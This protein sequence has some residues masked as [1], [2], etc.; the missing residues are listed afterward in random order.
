MSLDISTCRRQWCRSTF[1]DNDMSRPP[2][3]LTTLIFRLG[4]IH[5][6]GQFRKKKLWNI[7]R[8]QII[9]HYR[10]IGQ[11]HIFFWKRKQKSRK[12][13][14]YFTF[15]NNF[16]LRSGTP[17]FILKSS[18]NLILHIL[19]NKSTILTFLEN[20]FFCEKNSNLKNAKNIFFLTQV[21]LY[22]KM[23]RIK[24]SETFRMNV[25]Y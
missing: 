9:G 14:S 5:V 21:Y 1:F 23:C 16:F 25:N 13:Y 10:K 3:S 15:S 12:D 18:Q 22:T 6:I 7:W 8:S 24:L 4:R 19:V 11:I 2:M 20:F 17:T